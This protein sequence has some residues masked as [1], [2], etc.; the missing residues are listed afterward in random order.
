MNEYLFAR[1]HFQRGP[2]AILRVMKLNA[3]NRHFQYQAIDQ[4]AKA[5]YQGIDR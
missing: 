2:E 1:A 5:N 3:E 4:L